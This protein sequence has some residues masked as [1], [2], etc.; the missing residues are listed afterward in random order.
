MLNE[1]LLIKKLQAKENIAFQELSNVFGPRLFRTAK[2]LTTNEQEAEELVSDAL[3]D[4]FF[5]IKKFK[6]KSSLFSW[7]YR[8]L[9]NNFYD[10]LR[11]RKREVAFK[12][13]FQH[14]ARS[15]DTPDKETLFVFQQYLP[16]LLS[17]LSHDQREV[18]LLK[19][20]EGMKVKEIARSLKIPEST[21]NIRLYRARINLR[22]I[23]K[24]SKFLPGNTPY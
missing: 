10:R 8:I 2:L 9:L 12:A 3:A 24:K 14:A 20:L 4:A 23:L 13:S 7:L 19:Y 1:A 22:K 11:R 18:V 6:Q 17:S 16:D 15:I 21:V 5:D